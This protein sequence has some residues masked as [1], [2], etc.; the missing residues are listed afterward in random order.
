MIGRKNQSS[1]LLRRWSRVR[2]PANPPLRKHQYHHGKHWLEFTS[3]NSEKYRHRLSSG[4]GVLI[5]SGVVCSFLLHLCFTPV[6][7]IR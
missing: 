5:L 4:W 6:D 1:A 7:P 2:V 3:G